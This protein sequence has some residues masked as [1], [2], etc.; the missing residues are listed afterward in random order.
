MNASDP[1]L[2]SIKLLAPTGRSTT[3]ALAM[4]NER[5]VADV[6]HQRVADIP[7]EDHGLRDILWL[8]VGRAGGE[9]AEV[10]RVGLGGRCR[11]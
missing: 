8:G 3:C 4:I 2:Q 6:L 5:K 1:W 9:D 7:V 11:A 10:E